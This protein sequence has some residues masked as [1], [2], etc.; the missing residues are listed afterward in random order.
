MIFGIENN[1]A[2]TM[3]E[4]EIRILK[5]L[6]ISGTPTG[7]ICQHPEHGSQNDYSRSEVECQTLICQTAAKHYE[8]YP[9]SSIPPAAGQ[10]LRS[11]YS[12]TWTLK[13]RHRSN[14]VYYR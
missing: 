2:K 11:R 13:V 4:F 6:D 5:D 7:Q 9:C 14:K 8:G 10:S 12:R 1:I 3:S